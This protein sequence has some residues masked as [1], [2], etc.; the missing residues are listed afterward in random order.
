MLFFLILLVIVLINVILASRGALKGSPK[1]LWFLYAA[2]VVEYS[3]YGG[4]NLAFV[5]FLSADVGLSDQQAGSYIGVWSML[6]TIATILVGAVCDAIGIKRTLILGTLLLLFARVF[7]PLS[8]SLLWVTL[9]SFVPIALGTAIVGPVLSVGIKR[10]TTSEGAALGFGLFYTLM[11]V[12]WAAGGLIF[13]GIRTA[14]GEHAMVAI[15]LL[16]GE[17]S[18][19]QVIF[20]ASLVLTIPTLLLVLFMREGVERMDDGSIVVTPAAPRAEGTMWHATA[21]VMKKAAADTGRI[22]G[23]AVSERAFWVFIFLLAI[24]VPVRMVFFHFH[25]T[26]PKYGIRVLGDGVKIGNIYS[27]LNPVLIV[28][29][30]PVIAAL[31]K[32]VSSYRMMSI[33]TAVSAGAVFLAALPPSLYEPLMGTWLADL[34]FNTWLGVPVGQQTPLFFVMIVY[35]MVFTVGEAIWSPRLLQ[36][37]AEI[38]PAGREGSYIALSYLPF[39]AAKLV[40]GPLSGWLLTTY[41]PERTFI[42]KLAD[43]PL[44]VMGA[45]SPYADHGMIWLIVGGMALVSP[46]AFVAFAKVFHM[47]ER[48]ELYGKVETPA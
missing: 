9:L 47:A 7:M 1:E 36:F 6:V 12:G 40:V 11:N 37:T 31:T 27:V 4:A 26:F 32:K 42:L 44:R 30:V 3:A 2:K 43:E 41:T 21:V 24:P 8:D 23:K 19:Y 35:V 39:F 25:Y 20:T 46:I 48:K 5:L 17:M 14:L 18:T 22:F 16:G 38:A 34:V 33:G 13:D 28:L 45:V 10:F 29:L 15:P